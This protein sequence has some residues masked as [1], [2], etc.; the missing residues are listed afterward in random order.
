M[1]LGF[2]VSELFV[3][4]KRFKIFDGFGNQRVGCFLNFARLRFVMQPDAFRFLLHLG[5]LLVNK[6]LSFRNSSLCLLLT[7]GNFLFGGFLC[8]GN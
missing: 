1:R 5:K 4:P 2:C 7:R 3:F 8:F 6:L